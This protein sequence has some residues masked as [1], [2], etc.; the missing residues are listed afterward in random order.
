MATSCVHHISIEINCGFARTAIREL[1]P[2]NE[3][4]DKQQRARKFKQL[5]DGCSGFGF[6]TGYREKTARDCTKSFRYLTKWHPKKKG[7]NTRKNF[8]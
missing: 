6:G 5:Y 4:V 7:N 8:H 3:Q 1:T 2:R